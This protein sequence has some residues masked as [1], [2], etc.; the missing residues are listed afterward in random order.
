MRNLVVMLSRGIGLCGV[1]LLLEDDGDDV[2][3]PR[4]AVSFLQVQVRA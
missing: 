3:S 4:E 1:D 2:L